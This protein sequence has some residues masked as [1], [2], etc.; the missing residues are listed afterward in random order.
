VDEAQNLGPEALEE[1]RLLSNLQADKETLLQVI[2]VGQP[3][4][5]ERL[6]QPALRQ[7]AQRVAVHYHL[8]PL[9]LA[10][11]KEYVRFRL[12]RAGGNDIFTDSALE[13][14]Y[15]YTQGVPRR[16]N[17][18]CDLALVA[19]FAEGRQEIDGDFIDV[20]VAAQGGALEGPEEAEAVPE[21][22]TQKAARV[23]IAATRIDDNHLRAEMMELANRLSRLEGLVL[24]MTGQLMPV[25]SK[26]LALPTRPEITLPEDN[27]PSPIENHADAP[28]PETFPKNRLNWWQRFWKS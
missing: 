1:I 12:T 15:S 18:W 16:L 10:E 3:S 23:S 19:G 26:F 20:V 22:D 9:D 13:K 11:T 25:I 4:L 27:I 8:R 6:R 28:P 21:A 17:A 14:L 24:E 2:I 5:R 7:L